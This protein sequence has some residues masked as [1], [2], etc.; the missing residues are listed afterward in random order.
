[1]IQNRAITVPIVV[2]AGL[3]S[4]VA[5]LA[6]SARPAK[7]GGPD[8]RT[9][10]VVD[11]THAFDSDTIYWPTSPT[12]F[13]LTSLTSGMTPGGW[14]YSANS[15]CAPE[16]GGTHM[17]APIHFGR[18]KK[19]ADQIDVR[20]LVAPAV[21]IDVTAAAAADADY[22]VTLADVRAWEKKNGTIPGGA[23]ALLRTGWSRRWPDRKRYLGDDTPGDASNLHFPSYGPDAA[24]F[25]LVERRCGALGVD[26]ASIDP[27]DSK[28]FPVHRLL[29]E[30]N[31][32]GLENLDDLGAVPVHG[33]WIVALPMKIAS[34]SGGPLRAIALVP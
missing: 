8:L 29:A 23:I 34:G 10:K 1:V 19:T 5:I 21:V 31:A 26:T 33:A 16:H 3:A 7:P 17:D 32:P 6:A 22:R 25:L 9:A 11:L 12:R 20:Q 30:A 15:F 18:G 4:L 28:D 2:A 27:G 14:F 13:E 24:R